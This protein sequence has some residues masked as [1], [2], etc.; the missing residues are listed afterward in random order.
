MLGPAAMV[1][2]GYMDPG[3]WAT[4]LEGGARFGYGLLWVLVASNAI[5]LTLQTLT[6]RLG[7][8][9]G[10]DLA[11]AC[12]AH[13]SRPVTVALWLLAELAILACDLAEVLGSAVAL[14][15][16]FGLPM[17]AGALVTVLDVFLLLALQRR[18]MRA[19]YAFIVVLVTTIAVCM[20]IELVLVRPDVGAMAR[21][22]VPRMNG[23][24]LYLVIG[25]LGATVMPHNLYLQSAL[26]RRQD[27]ATPERVTEWLRSSFR[28]TG[29][30]LNVALLVNGAILVLSA[31]VF[32]TRGL[33]VDDLREAHRLL[34]PLVGTGLASALFAI[35][36]LCAGQSATLTGTLA[37]Q[38]VME[39]FVHMH[40]SPVVRRTVTRMLAVVPAVVVLWLV[41]E[42]STMP[43]LIAS[44]VVL[45]LQLPFAVVPLVRLTNSPELMG[46][47]A[48][49][50]V[51]RV[52][53]ALCALL[54]T[55]ANSALV[56]H[57]VNTLRPS[58]P[59]VAS[60]LAAVGL[61]GLA[62]LAWVTLVPLRH[63]GP[64]PV[65]PESEDS[66]GMRL[67]TT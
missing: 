8:V 21:G 28:S 67:T 64:T 27:R 51:V 38:I 9:T 40:V 29:A 20:G 33:A 6:A 4:D 59:M 19:L 25:I 66:L 30:A 58:Y 55:V 60:G 10:L 65:V 13:F 37:G 16:L 14:K 49:R 32:A 43:M 50:P 42:D 2:V 26:V 23:E 11:S 57:M 22:L 17:V 52:L 54:V 36:L 63:G 18:G 62:L 1:S 45:S 31:A 5:A 48:S 7:L 41:G 39:G 53:A 44:Q 15:L 46:T 47:F 61:A 12:R 56:V 24:S 34:A 3:N 35:A